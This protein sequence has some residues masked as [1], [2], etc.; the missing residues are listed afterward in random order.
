MMTVTCVEALSEELL[1][2]VATIA[3]VTAGARFAGAAICS[4][5]LLVMVMLA[6]LCREGSAALV[7]VRRGRGRMERVKAG[8]GPANEGREI[9]G[10]AN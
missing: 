8:E 10:F 6:E 7:A 1:A 3:L 5:K 9:R 2:L 4:V